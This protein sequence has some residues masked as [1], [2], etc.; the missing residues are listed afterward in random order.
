MYPSAMRLAVHA[1]VARPGL[2][3]LTISSLC[4]GQEPSLPRSIPWMTTDEGTLALELVRE[5]PCRGRLTIDPVQ[6]RVSWRGVAGE[7]PCPD[8]FEAAFDDVQSVRMRS[9]AGFILETRTQPR[10][11]LIPAPH[12]AWLGKAPTAGASGGAVAAADTD[13]DAPEALEPAAPELPSDVVADT[14]RAVDR[15]REVLGLSTQPATVLREA[16]YGPPADTTVAE[17]LQSPLSHAGRSVHLRGRLEPIAGDNTRYRL[18]AADQALAVLAEPELGA[19]IQAQLPSWQQ[20][21]VE[22]FGRFRRSQDAAPGDADYV[23]SIWECAPEGERAIGEGRRTTVG[24]LIA[25]PKAFVGQPVRVVGKFRGR[26][27]YADLPDKA[28]HDRGEWVI[29]DD[30]YAVWVAG[31]PAGPG[32][33]LDLGSPDDTR[34]WVEVAGT[35]LLKD[36]RVLLQAQLVSIVPPPP[37]AR[38]LQSRLSIAGRETPPA[39]IFAMPMEGEPVRP[40]ARFV[41]QFSKQ[42]D[43]ESFRGRIR[44]RYAGET[45]DEGF[46]VTTHYDPGLRSLVVD[47]GTL[48]RAGGQVEIQLLPGIIDADGLPLEPR[49]GRKADGAVDVLRYVVGG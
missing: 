34:R 14:R 37:G 32:F 35:P 17:L 44:L 13:P 15:L 24:A 47:P 6:R 28:A 43:E 25:T 42:M 31:K 27:L 22:L 1:V 7:S 39:V 45:T 11:V 40:D 48:L 8:P 10:L 3:V 49:P 26:N 30:R 5:G 33:S 16:L 23:V 20:R 41:I 19:Y 38:V 21:E 2:A 36:G 12:A 4:W 29:K 18:V 9:G 46:R